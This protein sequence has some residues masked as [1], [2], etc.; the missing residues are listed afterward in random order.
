MSTKS[1]KPKPEKKLALSPPVSLPA[2]SEQA[3]NEVRPPAYG[4]NF[5]EAAGKVVAY[6]NCYNRP[7]DYQTLEIGFADGTLYCFDL[8]PRIQ[9]RAQYQKQIRG[10]TEVIKDYG[11]VREEPDEDEE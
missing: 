11:V 8:L 2:T 4:T 3:R 6:I 7:D 1:Q 10:N 5:E 9:V